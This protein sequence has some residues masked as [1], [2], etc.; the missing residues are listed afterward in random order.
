MP[1]PESRPTLFLM[2]G[3]PGSGK[4]T[5]AR[6]LELLGPALRFTPDEWMIPL[7]GES[8]ADGKRDAL[9]G[10]LIWVATKTLQQRT[11]VILDFGFWGREERDALRHLASKLDVSCQLEYLAI[12]E[13]TQQDR[14]GRRNTASTHDAFSI[15]TAK[16]TQWRKAFQEP[17]LEEFQGEPV[18]AAPDGYQTW[19]GWMADRWPTSNGPDAVT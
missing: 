12:D 14:V 16:L 11:S 6:E 5:R 15:S 9:E 8:E 7:F 13:A 3:L 18:G 4:T 1:I 19:A 17:D 10:R 2:I